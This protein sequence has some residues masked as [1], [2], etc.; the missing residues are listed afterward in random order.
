MH[1]FKVAGVSALF[2][3]TVLAASVSSAPAYAQSDIIRHNEPTFPIASAIE[4]PAG[5]S[6]V[7]LSGMGAPVTNTKAPQKSL[8]AYGDMAAQTDGA[9]KRIEDTLAGMGLTMGD[10]VQMHVFMVADAKTKKLDFEGMMK[11][12]TKFF[13]TKSQP[14]LPVRSAFGVAQLANPGWLVEIEV[15]AVRPSHH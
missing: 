4:V 6:T 1:I 3:T 9:L 2:T 5:S 12:Y 8:E 13:G 14:N 10:V 15:V 7:Y 11:G